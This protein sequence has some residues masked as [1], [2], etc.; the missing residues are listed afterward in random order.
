[1]TTLDAAEIFEAMHALRGRG[2]KP[3]KLYVGEGG[4]KDLSN[5]ATVKAVDDD[6]ESED[7]KIGNF[8]G[9][10]VVEVDWLGGHDAQLVDSDAAEFYK[11][12]KIMIY[13]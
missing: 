13:P 8:G 9:L 1:M 6:D 5:A 4:M 7:E 2:H 11:S 10:D 3:D 12:A